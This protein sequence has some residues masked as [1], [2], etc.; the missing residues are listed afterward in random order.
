MINF[1]ITLARKA[2]WFVAQRLAN[3]PPILREV[4]IQ[5]L[6]FAVSVGGQSILYPPCDAKAL[7]VIRAVEVEDVREVIEILAIEDVASATVITLQ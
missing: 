3:E 4:T 1:N 2:A 5:G 7:A 6:D